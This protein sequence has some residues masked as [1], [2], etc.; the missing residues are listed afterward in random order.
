MRPIRLRAV[1][2]IDERLHLIA[3]ELDVRLA[4][5]GRSVF[6][7]LDGRDGVLVEPCF[8]RVGDAEAANLSLTAALPQAGVTNPV[9]AELLLLDPRPIPLVVMS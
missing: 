2:A 6:A 8:A 3:N 4:A 7:V 9:A 1:A 5:T